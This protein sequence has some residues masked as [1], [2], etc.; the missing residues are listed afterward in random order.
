MAKRK[1]VMIIVIGLLLLAYG[2]Y[3]LWPRKMQVYRQSVIHE[4]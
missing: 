3:R 4:R 2:T 1:A